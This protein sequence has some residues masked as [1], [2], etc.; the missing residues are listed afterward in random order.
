MKFRFTMNGT[1]WYDMLD[2]VALVSYD[3]ST[4]FKTWV[5]FARSYRKDGLAA[6]IEYRM[7][8]AG[9]FQT[10]QRMDGR[11]PLLLAAYKRR[12]KIG[13]QM[14]ATPKPP[15]TPDP[16]WRKGMTSKEWQEANGFAPVE[17]TVH[18]YPLTPDEALDA[19]DAPDDE[20][21]EIWGM[22]E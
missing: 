3:Y 10:I 5:A 8:E 16:E 11:E 22:Q 21:D 7:D 17:D 13:K 19:P 18:K 2:H 9:E 14:Y 1:L 15:R 12:N 4:E 20:W 6:F